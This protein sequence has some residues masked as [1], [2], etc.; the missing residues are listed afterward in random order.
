MAHNN[1]S[2]HFGARSNSES[3][4]RKIKMQD[5]LMFTFGF[6]ILA[7]YVYFMMTTKAQQED[8][9]RNF[10]VDDKSDQIEEKEQSLP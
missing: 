4:Q 7:V 10:G 3:T 8:I 6:I 2:I 9:E 5:S 1:L